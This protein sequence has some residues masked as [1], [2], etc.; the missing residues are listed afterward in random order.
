MRACAIDYKLSTIGKAQLLPDGLQ[1]IAREPIQA[2]SM[3][4]LYLARSVDVHQ[5]RT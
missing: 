2:G 5:L 4:A 3:A 1:L